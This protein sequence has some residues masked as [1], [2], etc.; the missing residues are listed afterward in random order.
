MKL[1][2]TWMEKNTPG[3]ALVI[4]ERLPDD[5]FMNAD[6]TLVAF[7]L[8]TLAKEWAMQMKRKG[9]EGRLMLQVSEDG[10]FI[11]FS[12]M[13]SVLIYTHEEAMR[14]FF[15]DVDH[16]SYL[17]C[18]EIVREHDKLNNFCGCRINVK[19]ETESP[20]CCIWFTVPK[21]C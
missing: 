21:Y 10:G 18:K 1:Q 13:T 2:V 15:P 11:R 19:M 8:E 4:D 16:Y 6:S 12:F 20:G 9:G 14:L 3:V 7:M 5:S 17:L